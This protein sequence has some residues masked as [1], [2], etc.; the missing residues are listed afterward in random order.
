MMRL[1]QA[2]WEGTVTGFGAVFSTANLRR[3]NLSKPILPKRAIV[4]V[5][6][7][8]DQAQRRDSA[9]FRMTPDEGTDINTL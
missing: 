1:A 4:P 8:V 5:G 6:L 9:S 7:F 2:N 3:S